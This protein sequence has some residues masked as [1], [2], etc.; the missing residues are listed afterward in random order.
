MTPITEPGIYV[1]GSSDDYF[2]DPCPEPSLNQ[3]LIKVGDEAAPL[4]MAFEHVRLNPYNRRDDSSRAQWLGSAVH[5]LALGAGKEVAVLRYPDFKH[6]SARNARD[7]AIRRNEIPIL[8]RDYERSLAMAKRARRLIEETAAGEPFYTEVPV[9]WREPTRFGAVWA[10]ALLDI[11][12]PS[13]GRIVDLKTTRGRATSV[14]VSRDVAANGY[15]IQDPWYL[16]GVAQAD[17]ELAGRVTFEFLYVESDAPHGHALHRMGEE[18]RYPASRVCDRQAESFAQGMTSGQWPGYPR[19]T[20][21]FE[22]A[23]WHIQARLNAE[24]AEG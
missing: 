19:Q 22:T 13:R 3:S 6:S 14:G 17:P 20:Q 10:R 24:L 15:D 11:W 2:L 8:E 18:S 12:I 5:R 21:R 7:E 1:G 23:G 16:R 4:H 9:Y